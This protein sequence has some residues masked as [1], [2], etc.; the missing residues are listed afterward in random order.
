MDDL[1]MTKLKLKLGFEIPEN[2]KSKW[3]KT[4]SIRLRVFNTQI[5]DGVYAH[6]NKDN[7]EMNCIYLEKN[8][9]HLCKKALH[10]SN[11]SPKQ[12]RDFYDQYYINLDKLEQ[13]KL[14]DR[15]AFPKEK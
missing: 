13:K 2:I 6:H 9:N 12:Y 4:L 14:T 7:A 5:F 1:K 11:I 15:K 10:D 8:F 3:V